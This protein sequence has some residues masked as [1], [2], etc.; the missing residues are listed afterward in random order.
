MLTSAAACFKSASAAVFESARYVTIDYTS[1]TIWV[2]HPYKGIYRIRF[3]DSSHGSVKLYTAKNGLVNVNNNFIFNLFS[4]SKTKFN[5]MDMLT[6]NA[7]VDMSG[8][9]QTKPRLV[10]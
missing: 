5:L 6:F 9:E 2:A 4:D 8:Q 3:D 10:N 7:S 1:H